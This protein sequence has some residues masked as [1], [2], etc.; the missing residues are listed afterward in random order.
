MAMDEKVEAI[1]V[2][3]EQR[4]KYSVAL[5]RESMKRQRKELAWTKAEIP[6]L[7]KRYKQLE[8]DIKQLEKLIKSAPNF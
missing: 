5:I 4:V 3:E 6:K 8:K 2:T 1:H 7:Q